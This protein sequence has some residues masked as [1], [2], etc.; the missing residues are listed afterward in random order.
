MMGPSMGGRGDAAKD[1]LAR[2]DPKLQDVRKAVG[3]GSG[4]GV[5]AE[6]LLGAARNKG[7]TAGGAMTNSVD[8]LRVGGVGDSFT[9]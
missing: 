9:A 8:L 4:G 3:K 1:A 7:G 2:D 5:S 6:V